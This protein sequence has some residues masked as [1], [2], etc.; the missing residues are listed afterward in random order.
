MSLRSWVANGL[1]GDRPSASR[2]PPLGLRRLRK[3]V[4][5]CADVEA[6]ADAVAGAEA[7]DRDRAGVSF[8]GATSDEASSSSAAIVSAGGA[9]RAAAATRAAATAATGRRGRAR[10]WRRRRPTPRRQRRGRPRRRRHRGGGGVAL[11]A[12]RVRAPWLTRYSAHPA[13]SSARTS[14]RNPRRAIM[15]RNPR[16]ANFG[17]Q[18]SARNFTSASRTANG[19][20][21][22]L[23]AA[24][25]ERPARQDRYRRLRDGRRC[26]GRLRAVRLREAD[27]AMRRRL[28]RVKSASCPAFMPIL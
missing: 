17:A 6:D 26:G 19:G 13:H 1:D 4:R 2:A 24:R 9:D 16:R 21:P 12:D 8:A 10:R 20:A 18:S 7:A 28:Q 14:A 5:R 25:A 11:D 23:C 15:E 22:V 27:R 3:R